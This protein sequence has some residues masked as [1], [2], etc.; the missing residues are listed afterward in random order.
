MSTGV[1]GLITKV[2]KSVVSQLNSANQL[3]DIAAELVTLADK[4]PAENENIKATL[5]N[6]AI[7]VYRQANSISESATEI[8]SGLAKVVGQ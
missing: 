5:H 8:G 6:E 7:K 4:L 2:R 3:Y 1:E